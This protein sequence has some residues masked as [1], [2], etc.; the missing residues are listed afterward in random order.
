MSL[1]TAVGKASVEEGAMK[2]SDSSVQ[3]HRVSAT[4]KA[5]VQKVIAQG[6]LMCS[7][8]T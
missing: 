7:D 2:I 8:M 1:H 6:I 3:T 5:R 4:D